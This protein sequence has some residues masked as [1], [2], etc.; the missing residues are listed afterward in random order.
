MH[1]FLSFSLYLKVIAWKEIQ[2]TSVETCFCNIRWHIGQEWEGC[3]AIHRYIH[4]AIRRGGNLVQGAQEG[5][6]KHTSLAHPPLFSK[7]SPGIKAWLLA[8]LKR[9]W[10]QKRRECATPSLLGKIRLCSCS[11]DF[12]VTN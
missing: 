12:K 9:K 2:A 8:F 6:N 10:T 5:I 11:Q 7:E 1:N 4:S 3:F